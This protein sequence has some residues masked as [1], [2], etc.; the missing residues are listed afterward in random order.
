MKRSS[1]RA[2]II[3]RYCKRCRDALWPTGIAK[4]TRIVGRYTVLCV[5]C[6]DGSVDQHGFLYLHTEGGRFLTLAY[7]DP[8][9]VHTLPAAVN[10]L[11]E[12]LGTFW[13]IVAFG[14][15]G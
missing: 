4:A 5:P 2:G 1:P 7:P 9:T 3:P 12:V 13:L 6:G 14:G 10:D 11:T 15:M 8:H